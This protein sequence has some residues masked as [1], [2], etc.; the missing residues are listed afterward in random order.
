M[1]RSSVAS[2]VASSADDERRA[3]I[4]GSRCVRS[5]YTR[6]G[7]SDNFCQ[8]FALRK[9]SLCVGATGPTLELGQWRLQCCR[10]MVSSAAAACQSFETASHAQSELTGN[11]ENRTGRRSSESVSINCVRAEKLKFWRRREHSKNLETHTTHRSLRP[12]RSAQPALKALHT[13][14]RIPSSFSARKNQ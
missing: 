3:R 13:K 7:I 9:H 11:V 10:Q 6:R 14:Q 5:S 1:R 8:P 12:H 4:V 2:K